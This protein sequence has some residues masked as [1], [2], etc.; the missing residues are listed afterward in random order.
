[1]SLEFIFIGYALLSFILIIAQWI[2][3]TEK[4]RELRKRAQGFKR[5]NFILK[6]LTEYSDKKIKFSQ[7]K[8]LE[9]L[10][11]QAGFKTT[12]AE[13]LLYRIISACIF[14]FIFFYIF[15]NPILGIAVFAVGFFLPIQI[16]KGIRNTR[17]EKMDKQVGSFMQMFTKRYEATDSFHKAFELSVNEFKGQ[18]PLYK[19]LQTAI[20]DLSVG[21]KET[22]T[23]SDLA[24][25]TGN[26]YLERLAD[27]Y[28]ISS[29]IGTKNIRAKLLGDAYIQYSENDED[30]ATTKR[31][32]SEVKREGKVL[33]GAVPFFAFIMGTQDANYLD[34]MTG[35]LAGKIGV[36]FIIVIMFGAYWFIENKIGAPLE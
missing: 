29:E 5:E 30:Q 15:K 12:Y 16:I 13:L 18:D 22:E 21:K 11:L 14:G 34:V 20:L 36:V 1:M 24:L 25:R 31:E 28:K 26:I 33:I 8:K 17:V 2:A 19:E 35:T 23:M 9:T 4:N 32:L 10:A 3:F 27:Y 6:K 7:R